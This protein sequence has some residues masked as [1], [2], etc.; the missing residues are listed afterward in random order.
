[1]LRDLGLSCTA[2]TIGP[3][4]YGHAPIWEFFPPY[5]WPN[6]LPSLFC[7]APAA[8]CFTFFDANIFC[9]V[10]IYTFP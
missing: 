6:A 2:G 8:D 5:R 4:R 10:I 9:C 3:F 1:M 7:L